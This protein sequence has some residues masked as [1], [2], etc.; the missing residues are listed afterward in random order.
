MPDTLAWLTDVHLDFVE[1]EGRERLAGMI[2]RSGATGVV[3]TGDIAIATNVIE[4]VEEMAAMVRRPIWFVLGNHD[5]YRG[6]IADVRARARALTEQGR[7]VSWL[8]AAGVVRLD[9]ATA[10]VGHDGWGDGR[11]GNRGSR[12]ELND[13]YLIEELTGLDR[14]ERFARI[15]ALGDEA[16]A[17]LARAVGDALAWAR[18][19]IVAIHVPPFREACWHEGKV[20]DDEGLPFFACGA[21]GEALRALMQAHPAARMTVLCGH[22]HSG[23]TA[24]ILPNLRVRTG[25]ALYGHPAVQD[26]I[27]L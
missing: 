26:V 22:T 6:S 27:H 8:P 15:G 18:H 13:F 12:L 19:V 2:E 1:R 11:L 4:R 16:A 9:A 25:A 10:L 21:A 20:S 7:G 3:V 24:D 14:D 17:Y 5:F 23:G